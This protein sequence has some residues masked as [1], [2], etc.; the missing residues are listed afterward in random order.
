MDGNIK[1]QSLTFHVITEQHHDAIKLLNE[2]F[3]LNTWAS[4]KSLNYL[5]NEFP[6]HENV[7]HEEL[8]GSGIQGIFNKLVLINSNYF[9]SGPEGCAHARRTL[10]RNGNPNILNNITR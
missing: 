8:E 9:I 3:E 4:M 6:N 5:Y 2:T 1:A 7:I 10:M